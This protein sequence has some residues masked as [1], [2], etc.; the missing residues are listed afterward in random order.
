MKLLTNYII[1]I[2]I[3]FFCTST[4]GQSDFATI[5]IY[6]PK[7]TYGSGA[8][9]HIIMNGEKI[10]YLKNGGHLEYKIFNSDSITIGI[11]ASAIGSKSKVQKYDVYLEKGKSYYFQTIPKFSKTIMEQIDSPIS[12]K[13]LNYRHFKMYSD[14]KD[15]SILLNTSSNEKSSA[16]KLRELKQL[17]DDG[18][19][20]LDDFEKKKEELLNKY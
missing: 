10:C 8:R 13:K 20:T 7:M 19:I 17:L 15:N 2:F 4:Y 1:I 9:H 18:I 14:F 5:N 11:Y 16:D 12:D 3:I 6:R